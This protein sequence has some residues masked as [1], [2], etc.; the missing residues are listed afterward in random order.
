MCTYIAWRSLEALLDL[1]LQIC[2]KCTTI[3]NCSI[4][5]NGHGLITAQAELESQSEAELRPVVTFNDSSARCKWKIIGGAGFKE[6]RQRW[7]QLP[8]DL[9]MT[10]RPAWP[11]QSRR[12]QAGDSSM[13]SISVCGRNRKINCS[14]GLAARWWWWTCSNCWIIVNILFLIL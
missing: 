10:S 3:Y 13:D 9:L 11:E 5:N 1:R 2:I 6:C 12:G 14:T 7:R 4:C 8:G